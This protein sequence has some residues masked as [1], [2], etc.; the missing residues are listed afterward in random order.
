MHKIFDYRLKAHFNN[1]LW[2][3]KNGFC[4]FQSSIFSFSLLFRFSRL[5]KSLCWIGDELLY[6]AILHFFSDIKTVI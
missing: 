3:V 4:G 5:R 6:R 1:I 2:S